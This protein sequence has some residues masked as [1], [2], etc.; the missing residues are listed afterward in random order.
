MYADGCVYSSKKSGKW[1]KLDLKSDDISLLYLIADKTKN[2]CPIKTY[3][4]NKNQYF[5]HQDKNYEFVHCMSRLS[6]RSDKLVDDLIKLGC[7]SKKTFDIKFPSFD[8]VPHN[9]IRHFIRGY[10]DG[11]GSISCSKRKSSS[12]LRDFYLH[13]SI[14]F[15]G[16]YD[17][18]LPLKDF[19]INNI[20]NFTGDI[21]NRWDNNT[22]NCTLAIDGNNIIE[23]I[24]DWLYGD[25]S[26]YLE[27]KYEK[28]LLLK[29]EIKIKNEVKKYAD[30]HRNSMR[31]EAFNIYKNGMYIGTSDNRRKIERES[32]ILFGEH[33][34][35]ISL[36]RCLK[37]I[38]ENYHGF[39]F[40]F[41]SED[42]EI[43]NPKYICCG[44]ENLKSR[45]KI[46]QYDSQKNFIRYWDSL[47]EAYEFLG[48]ND[49]NSGITACCQGKQR[50]AYGYIWE[51]VN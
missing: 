37:N 49:N 15:T 9:L 41:V 26:I 43:E 22:N 17:F 4:Y 2:E 14:T 10:F 16:T 5:P 18:I 35:R 47:K 36:T 30:S 28:Y 11:D 33:I 42:I 45:R 27:R 46:A 20:V 13:F 21:R 25:S 40:V 12:K 6:M 7:T 3:T 48:L 1:A 8:V 34:S 23:K 39:S 32:D 24:L 51:Y 50:T 19:L 31:K 29:N 38:D 44:K